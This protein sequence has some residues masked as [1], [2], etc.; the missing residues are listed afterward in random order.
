M[1]SEV[2]LIWA[3]STSGVIGRGGGI[4]W[5]LPEDQ[6]RFKDLTMGQAVVMG[7]LT[8]ESLPA[9]VRPL[10]GRRN[11]VLTHRPDYV[12]DG[13]DVVASL[14]DALTDASVWVI[15]GAQIYAAAL[16]IATRCE[17]TE[18][19][20]DLPRQDADVMA[21]VLDESWIGVAGD[22]LT[23]TSSLRYR[24]YSYRRA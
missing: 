13:A 12:A 18:I 8:W 11:V 1:R 9:K 15:G 10:P 20:I 24:F 19:E 14:E 2:G 21:P 16:P 4:P 7:R 23:S 22:W 6:A 3:Q 17:V 5:R